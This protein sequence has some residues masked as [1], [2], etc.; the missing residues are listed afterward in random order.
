MGHSPHR[1][2]SASRKKGSSTITFNNPPQSPNESASNRNVDFVVAQSPKAMAH[3]SPGSAED[4]AHLQDHTTYSR[5]SNSRGVLGSLGATAASRKTDKSRP[6]TEATPTWRNTPSW[7]STGWYSRGSLIDSA[8]DNQVAPALRHGRSQPADNSHRWRPRYGAVISKSFPFRPAPSQAS[9]LGWSRFPLAGEVESMGNFIY[10][11]TN[12]K[13]GSA[14]LSNTSFDRPGGLSRLNPY[15]PP[16]LKGGQLQN[17]RSTVIKTADH[18]T[19]ME[20]RLRE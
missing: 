18:T 2:E 3:V 5:R 6:L 1:T 17:Y 9:K 7:E 12:D 10:L 8:T 16:R 11:M 4:Y 15:V 20:S 14:D 19:L 13:G